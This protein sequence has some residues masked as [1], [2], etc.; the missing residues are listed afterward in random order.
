MLI[1]RTRSS[2]AAKIIGH[3]GDVRRFASRNHYAS[4]NGT[5]PLDASSGDQ[6]RHRLNQLGNRQLNAA[7]HI[8][9]VCQTS[10][11]GSGQDLY[12]RKLAERKTPTEARRTLKRRLSDV[13][14]RH[15]VHD[16]KTSTQA[17]A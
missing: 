14:F 10:R 5:A 4:Y 13:V 11:P 3:S 9:A 15:L 8:S 2:N 1:F 16:L 7:I 12:R 6:N 17:A